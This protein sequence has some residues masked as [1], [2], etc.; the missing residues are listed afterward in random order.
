MIVLGFETSCDETSV[1]VV[2]GSAVLSNVIYS[3]ISEHAPFGGIVP[4]IASRDHI[5]KIA[6][7]TQ[8]ALTNANLSIEQIEAVAVTSQ[9]YWCSSRRRFI[10][11]IF[12]L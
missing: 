8:K 4:E 1:A 10:C 12:S 2:K 11:Q 7:L 5:R 6:L 9:P 3:Q